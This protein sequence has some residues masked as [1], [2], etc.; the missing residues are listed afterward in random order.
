M[1][2]RII[3]FLLMI[4]LISN[5]SVEILADNS[6]KQ[7]NTVDQNNK[8]GLSDSDLLA[9]LVPSI[10]IGIIALTIV[11][12][13]QVKANK[14][15]KNFEKFSDPVFNKINEQIS[16][17]LQNKKDPRFRKIIRLVQ[18]AFGSKIEQFQET[19]GNIYVTTATSGEA[20]SVVNQNKIEKL[21]ALIIEL[22]NALTNAVRSEISETITFD[23]VNALYNGIESELGYNEKEA[24]KEQLKKAGKAI[25]EIPVPEFVTNDSVDVLFEKFQER[26]GFGALH[27]AMAPTEIVPEKDIQTEIAYSPIHKDLAKKFRISSDELRIKLK[28]KGAGVFKD[29]D[30]FYKVM[31]GEIIS[32]TVNNPVSFIQNIKIPTKGKKLYEGYRSPTIIEYSI[33]GFTEVNSA[34]IKIEQGIQP[35]SSSQYP[36]E[37]TIHS[38]VSGQLGLEPE[39]LTKLLTKAKEFGVFENQGKLYQIMEEG[40]NRRLSTLSEDYLPTMKLIGATPKIGTYEAGQI[41]EYRPVTTPRPVI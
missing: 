24:L 2:R 26:T 10:S 19:L 30:K 37:P 20:I 12:V 39:T 27:E 35:I 41:V 6:V 21:S 23:F 16:T 34:T 40:G 5:N 22:D 38:T 25:V 7:A 17:K 15:I 3:Y 28:D 33:G 11:I 8:A 14:F 29:G 18:K 1:K 13:R 31:G 9:I 32:E 36:Q 4:I